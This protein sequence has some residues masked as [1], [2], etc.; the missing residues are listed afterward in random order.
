MYPDRL[1]QF[2]PNRK[3]IKTEMYVENGVK[4]RPKKVKTLNGAVE[5]FKT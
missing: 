5:F 3:T 4:K 1:Y 2:Q